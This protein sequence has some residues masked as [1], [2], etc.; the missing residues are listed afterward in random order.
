[1]F[2]FLV[3]MVTPVAFDTIGYKFY[4]VWACTNAAFIVLIYVF[5]KPTPSLPSPTLDP[6]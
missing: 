2:T 1:M 4:I 6:S 3:V 5:C